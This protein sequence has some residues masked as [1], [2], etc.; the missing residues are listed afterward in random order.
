MDLEDLDHFLEE[1]VEAE[2]LIRP[3]EELVA[4]KTVS[5]DHTKKPLDKQP[6]KSLADR[7]PAKVPTVLATNTSDAKA[8]CFACQKDHDT[9]SCAVFKRMKPN[10][11]AQVLKSTGAC[12]RCLK[13]KHRAADCTTQISCSVQDCRSRH[14]TLLHG[15]DRVYPERGSS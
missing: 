1:T 7:N 15:A 9:T 2:R 14:H 3:T 10:E 13:G 4:A 6:T 8:S 11:R 12:F 5:R